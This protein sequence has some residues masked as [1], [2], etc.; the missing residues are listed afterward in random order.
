MKFAP[1]KCFE[2]AESPVVLTM[3]ETPLPQVQDTKYLGIIMS[4]TGPDWNQMAS[5][6]ALK[7]KNVTM[8]LTRIGFNKNLC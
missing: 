1:D 2:I 8:A 3:D 5:A 7:A 4:N 6:L